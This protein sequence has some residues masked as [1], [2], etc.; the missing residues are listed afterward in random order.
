[1]IHLCVNGGSLELLS[2]DRVP[3]GELT[4][5]QKS[6]VGEVDNTIYDI[7]EEISV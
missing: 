1:M 4:M 7:P 5:N 3:D 6:N 2:G